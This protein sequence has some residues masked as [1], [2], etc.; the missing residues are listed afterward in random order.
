MS[1]AR[2]YY[3]ADGITLYH[4]DC[5]TIPQWTEADVLVTDPPYG[6]G[7]SSSWGAND[8]AFA[9]EPRMTR[10]SDRVLTDEHTHT[11][12]QALQLWGS[13]K[14]GIVFGTWRAPKPPATRMR[15]IW[16]KGTIGP[17]GVYPWRPADEEIYLIGEWP[18]PR[19]SGGD[20][21]SVIQRHRI[22]GNA[23]PD[24]PTPKPVALLETLI[25]TCPAGVITDPFAGS[26][27]TLLAA[28]RQG[29]QAVGVE[30]DR[31]YCALIAR[32]LDQTDLF[33]GAVS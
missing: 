26:G 6:M 8:A 27:S 19:A 21:P 1:I 29:R 11:R 17:G 24:H 25:E 18:N 10:A 3:Q 9:G 22:L 16:D 4:G 15:L 30:I 32:R 33:A 13:H 28:R 20:R 12:D 5:L 14:P 23:R 2:P 31:R 7:M